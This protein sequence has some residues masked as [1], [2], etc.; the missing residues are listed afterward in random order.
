[1]KPN[2]VILLALACLSISGCGRRSTVPAQSLPA[3]SFRL[4]V[5]EVFADGDERVCSLRI[6]TRERPRISVRDRNGSYG[7][8]PSFANPQEDGL[9]RQWVASFAVSG[10][11][12]N[13]SD[14][15]YIK[16]KVRSG[17]GAT[18]TQVHQVPQQE[19]LETVMALTIR[20]GVYK[21]GTP[22]IIGRIQGGDLE[23]LVRPEVTHTATR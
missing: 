7:D 2:T 5:T 15:Q 18:I 10:V 6:E 3:G 9:Y 16:T 17:S 21:Q 1:M 22:L 13:G 23:L 4:S 8:W 11:T 14:K 19:P 12:P 20:D